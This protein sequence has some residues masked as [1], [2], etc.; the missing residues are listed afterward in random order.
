MNVIPQKAVLR[1]SRPGA[2]AR[3]SGWGPFRTLTNCNFEPGDK[4]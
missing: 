4:R 1:A 2:N 3:R